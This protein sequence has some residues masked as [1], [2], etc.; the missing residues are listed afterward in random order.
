MRSCITS[1]YIEFIIN[2]VS[3]RKHYNI[4]IMAYPE[5]GVEEIQQIDRF[6]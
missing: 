1:N 5:P 4:E 6:R 3:S 2:A